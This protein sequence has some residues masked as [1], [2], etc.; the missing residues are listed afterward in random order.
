MQ[1]S[2]LQCFTG[3]AWLQLSMDHRIKSGGDES[4]S[5]ACYSSGAKVCRENAIAYSEAFPGRGAA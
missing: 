2:R 3:A 5:V 4:E 1:R